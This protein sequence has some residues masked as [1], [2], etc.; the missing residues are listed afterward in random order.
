MTCLLQKPDIEEKLDILAESARYDV[1]LSSCNGNS[2]GGVGRLRDPLHPLT[3]WVY[4]AYVPGKGRVGILKILQANSC[5]NHCSYCAI[6]A[7]YDCPKRVRFKP[8]ELAEVFMQ[9]YR[10]R[11]VHGIFISSGV[12]NNPDYSM[13]QMIEAA[14]LL[15]NK[16]RFKD[17]IHLKLLPGVSESMIEQAVKVA[18]RV[19]VNL[20]LPSAGLLEPLAPEKRFNAD[21]LTPMAVAAKHIQAGL[22]REGAASHTTQFVI[23][24]G[25]ETDLDVLRTVDWV[26]TDYFVFRSYFSAYQP[27]TESHIDLQRQSSLL[28]EHRLYQCDFLLRGYG[29]RLAD[30]VFDDHGKLPLSTDP[31]TAHAIMHPELFPVD[32]NSDDEETLLRVPGIGRVS[33]SRIVSAR[34]HHSLVGLSD[35][36]KAGA[37]IRR[38]APYVVFSGKRDM[39]YEDASQGWLFER[40]P[41]GQ[42]NTGNKPVSGAANTAYLY[43]GQ[44]GKRL[45]Y[46]LGKSTDSVRCR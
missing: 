34:R 20:E 19:S 22:G 8:D 16:H 5:I 37:W 35:L 40:D 33:A 32:I 30:L 36:K 24:A 26:Y 1:C 41:P 46:A 27:V 18:N 4:P 10:T 17:Y 39:D 42:W 15:R 43:P 9:F 11:L 28:R 3:R 21:L 31:K 7:G 29:F 13:G 12:A 6:S 45:Y 14:M 44:T 2:A 38:A 25:E 23:G